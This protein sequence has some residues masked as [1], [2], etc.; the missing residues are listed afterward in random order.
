VSG[1]SHPEPAMSANPAID[2][3]AKN[4]LFRKTLEALAVLETLDCDSDVR[5][6]FKAELE[7]A[8]SHIASLKIVGESRLKT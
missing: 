8:K 6:R 4:A 3:R 1:E 7:A 2:V 5:S